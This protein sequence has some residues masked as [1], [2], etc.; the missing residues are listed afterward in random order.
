MIIRLHNALFGL[1]QRTTEDWALGLAARLVFAGTLAVYYWNAALT[2]VGEGFGGFFQVQDNAYWQMFGEST[3][4][5]FGYDVSQM[6]FFPY[7]LIAHVGTYAEF[8]L[9]ALVVLGFM[10]RLAA[11]G[12]VGFILV[13]SYVDVTVHDLDEK[14]IGGWF[15]S[16]PDAVIAD[17]RALWLFP[18][19]YLAI[20]GGGLLSLDWLLGGRRA[21][22]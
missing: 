4:A 21:L 10:T 19:V 7:G 14:S 9:P 2:K 6:P 13:Q 22:A 1:V 8:I 15:D 5:E 17:Q 18:L 11:L 16:L 12:M 3:I 20:R